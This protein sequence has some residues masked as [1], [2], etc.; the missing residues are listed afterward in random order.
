MGLLIFLKTI[1]FIERL[2]EFKMPDIPFVT[3]QQRRQNHQNRETTASSQD[4][5]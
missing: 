3:A 5:N 2:S 1:E 4:E